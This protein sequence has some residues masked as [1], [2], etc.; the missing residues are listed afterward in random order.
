MFDL[1]ALVLNRRDS[2][3]EA[4]HMAGHAA[5]DDE[6]EA[7]NREGPADECEYLNVITINL[8]RVSK[9][10]SGEIRIKCDYK[11]RMAAKADPAAAGKL[12]ATTKM[13]EREHEQA[14]A[15]PPLSGGPGS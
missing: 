15:R 9:Q 2:K 3:E 11:P 1:S 6:E 12:D 7:P 5:L 4:A 14:K 10:M 8:K 13:R